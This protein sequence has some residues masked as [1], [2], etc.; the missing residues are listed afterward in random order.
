MRKKRYVILFGAAAREKSANPRGKK[1]EPTDNLPRTTSRVGSAA[2]AEQLVW[3]S[4]KVNRLRMFFYLR[5]VG[6]NEAVPLDSTENCPSYQ[7]VNY[8]AG[9]GTWTVSRKRARVVVCPDG[10]ELVQP[11]SAGEVP[12]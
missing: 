12:P 10:L 3:L 6:N 7:L 4:Y 5:P 8:L 2:N 11:E 1:S 9:V